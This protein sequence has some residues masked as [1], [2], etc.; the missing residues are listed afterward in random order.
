MMRV[1][2]TFNNLRDAG[3]YAKT[4]AW[5]NDL[6]EWVLEIANDAFTHQQL[7]TKLL[8]NYMLTDDPKRNC[9]SP[10][11]PDPLP[12]HIAVSIQPS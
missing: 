10:F 11:F 12:R 4:E 6:A 9:K 3:L 5:R 7:D 2:A 1:Y 8:P